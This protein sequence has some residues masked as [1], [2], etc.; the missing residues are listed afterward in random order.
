MRGELGLRLQS[1]GDE[2]IRSEQVECGPS[3]RPEAQRGLE[4]TQ[5]GGTECEGLGRPSRFEVSLGAA[6][7]GGWG[8]G[9]PITPP[10]AEIGAHAGTQA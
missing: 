1:R 4:R 3:V 5:P 10:R 8:A 2:R 9:G 6:H 7:Q